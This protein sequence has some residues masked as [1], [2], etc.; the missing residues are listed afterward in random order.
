M[1]LIPSIGGSSTSNPF[2]IEPK[3]C[4]RRCPFSL[5][6]Y[7]TKHVGKGMP[8]DLRCPFL[9]NVR[10]GVNVVQQTIGFNQPLTEKNSHAAMSQKNAQAF[11]PW[12]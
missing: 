10:M 4:M 6:I 12:W 7:T 5:I 3:K 1:K 8:V 2:D 11:H 9:S